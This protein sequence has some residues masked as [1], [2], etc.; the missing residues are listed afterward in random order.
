MKH[1]PAPDN[2]LSKLRALVGKSRVL[3]DP[4][5]TANYR[6][7]FR[8]GGGSALAVVI[9]NSLVELWRVAQ[10]CVDNDVIM[11]VQ[12][13]NTGLTGG[14]TPIGHYDRDVVIISTVRLSDI[15]VINGGL[16]VLAFAGGRLY[17]LEDELNQY[18]REPHSVIGSSCIGASIVGGICNNSGGA[19][20]QRGPA[21]T[22]MSLYARVNEK[23]KL[24]MVNNLGIDLAED[25][26]TALA[27]LESRT[28]AHEDVKNLAKAASDF[29]YQARVR[30]IEASTPSRFNNDE[31]RLYEASGCAGKLIVFVVRLDTFPKPKQEKVF[32][33]G[34]NQTQVLTEVRK[35]ILT[36]FENLP[37]A[38]EYM[39]KSYFDVSDK[40]GKD[41]FI[42]IQKLG[43]NIMP[44]LF[45][46]KSRVDSWC[47][48]L[49][50]LPPYVADKILQGISKVFPD[51]L[52]KRVREYRG[53]FDHHLMLHMSDA[54]VQEAQ[55][56][57]KSFFL[58][59]EGDFFEC[60]K[61]EGDRAFLHR[62]VAGGAAKRYQMMNAKAFGDIM[63]LDIALARNEQEWFEKLPPNIDDLLEVKLYLGHFMCH[64]MHQDYIVK[65][66]VNADEVKSKLLAFFDAKGAEYPAEHNVGQQYQAKPALAAFYKKND[67]TNSLNPGI[68]KT[69]K[70]KYW[71]KDQS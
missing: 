36:T 71:S 32:Y 54:G 45:A 19:L 33:I 28:Y 48:K 17:E 26:E 13:A 38:G 69:P 11:I 27:T 41:S 66:G 6:K 44:K 31:R 16:Q 59:K 20:V 4:K 65:K 47:E 1:T 3:T 55:D 67:P 35:H 25:P 63:A 7:G 23:Q 9:P 21:Y 22:E 46:L 64:V 50:I 10:C 70:Y 39:H 2:F 15:H 52:P 37:V 51:H 12:A 34:T 14:S 40:Y 18:D 58:Q 68:G 60:T 29:D 57:F 49:P 24:E 8:F 30:D 62:F 61:D 5:K 43:S 42:A 56:F 53:R